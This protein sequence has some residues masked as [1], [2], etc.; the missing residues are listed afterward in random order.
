[1]D[2]IQLETAGE[3]FYVVQHS[4][5]AK[6]SGEGLLEWFRECAVEARKEG[7]VLLRYSVDDAEAPT[8]ALVEGWRKRPSDQGPIRWQLTLAD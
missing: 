7:A 2:G 5:A 6:L 4:E 8:M 3:P 1:M